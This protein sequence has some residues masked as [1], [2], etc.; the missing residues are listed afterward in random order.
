VRLPSAVN[1]RADRSAIDGVSGTHGRL[2]LP[3]REIER[4][5]SHFNGLGVIR[6]D[7]RKA[8]ANTGRLPGTYVPDGAV[9]NLPPLFESLVFMFL[10]IELL[11]LQV[12]Q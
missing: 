6:P 11:P 10:G 2:P 4:P 5:N 8:F 9:L 12:I 3:I 1:Y 7:E